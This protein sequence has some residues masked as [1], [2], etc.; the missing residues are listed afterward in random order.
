MTITYQ[1]GTKLYINLTN[2]CSNSCKFCVRRSDSGVGG[3]D[4]WLDNEPTAEEIIADIGDASQYNEIVFCGYGEPLVKLDTLVEV[5][6]HL[7]RNFPQLPIRVN[8]NGQAN[9][10]H[11]RNILPD[12]EGV[13]DIISISLNAS[14]S[15]KYQKICRSDYGE[16]AFRGVIDFIEE[17]KRFIPK[18]IASVVDYS[19][20]NVE[21]CR[22]LAKKLGVEFRL[23]QY[24]SN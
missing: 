6:R 5:S 9:L 11:D 24:Q 10:I 22:D 14:T 23:R 21:D 12:L 4:L 20:V 8:T 17:A 13:I 1:L 18:V 3:Y 7:K 16:Y 19:I 15:K 2:Q